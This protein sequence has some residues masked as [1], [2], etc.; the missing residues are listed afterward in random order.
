MNVQQA[1]H[2]ALLE[3]LEREGIALVHPTQTVNLA[4]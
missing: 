3:G 1:A 4:R 2:L